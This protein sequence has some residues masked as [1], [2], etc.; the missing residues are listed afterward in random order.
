MMGFAGLA[1]LAGFGALAALVTV[2][3]AFLVALWRGRYDTVDTA[4]GLGFVL[5]AVCSMLLVMA[6]FGGARPAV[7]AAIVAT[8]ATT[9]WGARLAIH[10]H[11]RNRSR[12]EDPRYREIAARGGK[13]RMFFRVY[14]TQ[15][16]V[17]WF[18]SLPVQFAQCR[19]LDGSAAGPALWAGL[20]VWGVG[21][22]F[23]SVGDEQLRRFRA[24]PANRG[25]VLDR[26]LWRYTRH[27]NYFGDACVWW[28]LFLMA[29]HH[30]PG[31]F[32]VLSPVVMTWLLARGT[33]KPLLE[34]DI[35]Q[36]RPDYAD[37]VRRTS[38]FLP[39]PPKRA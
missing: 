22:V 16:V 27:P 37:Y 3:V 21:F 1:G 26:G 31:A 38:G 24:D 32:T 39:L 8:T 6:G 18:V 13:A 11:L 12:A 2:T 17:M 30:V 14:L 10:L 7:P 4:W 20:V 28:G 35:R 19:G 34:R 5:I 23:E 36:R 25:R 9:V 15:G 33:G 29:C